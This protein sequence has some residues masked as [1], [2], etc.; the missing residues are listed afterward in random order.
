M[1]YFIT[2]DDG[3]YGDRFAALNPP[4]YNYHEALETAYRLDGEVPYEELTIC[5]DT[6]DYGTLEPYYPNFKGMKK[7]KGFSNILFEWC[8]QSDPWIWYYSEEDGA[9]LGAVCF[10]ADEYLEDSDDEDDYIDY[11]RSFGIPLKIKNK[12]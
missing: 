11:L 4:F 5:S 8:G 1:K 2:F 9:Y 3:P 7:F 6:G 12:E 10:Y